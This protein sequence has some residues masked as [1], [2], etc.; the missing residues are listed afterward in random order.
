MQDAR[1]FVDESGT[2]LDGLFPLFSFGQGM[3]RVLVAF[4]QRRKGGR[5]LRTLAGLR[6]HG[7]ERVGHLAHGG[8]DH[9]HIVFAVLRDDLDDLTNSVHTA[10]GSAAEF[11]D[12][13]QVTSLSPD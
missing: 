7:T 11:H 6:R 4:P 10:Y 3:D 9:H 8:Q 12:D 2:D 13:H 1:Q 5:G